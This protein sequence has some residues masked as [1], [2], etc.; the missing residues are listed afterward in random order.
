M[1]CDPI[2]IQLNNAAGIKKLIELDQ[3]FA[4]CIKKQALVDLAKAYETI[5]NK[6]YVQ[7]EVVLKIISEIN[8]EFFTTIN[9][10]G[11]RETVLKQEYKEKITNTVSKEF[12][13][14]VRSEL[15]ATEIR[16]KKEV[17]DRL[18]R[19]E[20]YYKTYLS[21]L[22]TQ[23]KDKVEESIVSGIVEKR[24]KDNLFKGD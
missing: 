15:E 1:T 23:I 4:V 21:N 11:Q 16:I 12:D 19:F 5:V 3:E 18:D 2:K 17:I 20:E 6:R 9:N 10:Y 13:R 7:D 14:I 24:V 8:S 22:E